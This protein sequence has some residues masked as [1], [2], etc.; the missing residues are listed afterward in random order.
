MRRILTL[1]LCL[2]SWQ[3]S[4]QLACAQSRKIDLRT[5]KGASAVKGQWRYHDVRIVEV[6]G[7]NRDGSP[8]RTY[9]YEPK[10][11]GP[12]FDDSGWEILEPERVSS[13]RGNGQ[14][15]FCW[16]R[17][18]VTLPPGVEGKSVFFQTTVDDYAEVWVDGQLPRKPGDVGGPIVAGFNV[19][20]R[21]E[22]K[23]PHPGKA[24]Q[25]AIFGINGPIS[26]TP[27]NWIFLG[28]TFLELVDKP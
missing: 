10:A 7:K 14:I 18:K 24:Y 1:V 12:G 11:K 26:D 27:T 20:N 6:A 8:N 25:I 19:P 9:S 5:K 22:L 13:A 28:P 15:C 2:A 4:T 16:Y 3:A 17:I 23:N 21:L